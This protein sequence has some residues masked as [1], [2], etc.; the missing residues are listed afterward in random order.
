VTVE[1]VE[2]GEVFAD[3]A[4]VVI[5]AR[6]TLNNISWP[7]VPGLSDLTIPVMHSA[8]WDNRS[9]KKPLSENRIP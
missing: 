9:V 7:Q 4:D 8:A 2:T 5:S 1:R 3:E 6:G